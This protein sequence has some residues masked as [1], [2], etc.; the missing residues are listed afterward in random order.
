[1]N[2][3]NSNE[4]KKKN[5]RKPIMIAVIVNLQFISSKKSTNFQN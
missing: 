1:M 4:N 3:K 2:E 5:I